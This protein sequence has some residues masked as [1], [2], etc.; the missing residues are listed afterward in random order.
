MKQSKTK[1]LAM[2]MSANVETGVLRKEKEEDK[3]KMCS[4]SYFG[5]PHQTLFES[6]LFYLSY[7][8][9]P[10]LRKKFVG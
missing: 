6:K 4:A 1:Y 7:A 8:L 10:D 9:F 2:P 3:E 5:A